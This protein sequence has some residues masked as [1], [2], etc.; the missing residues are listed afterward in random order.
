ML[1]AS[2]IFAIGAVVTL[3]TAAMILNGHLR[4]RRNHR[5]EVG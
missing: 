1:W 2:V 3:A 5:G 4:Y